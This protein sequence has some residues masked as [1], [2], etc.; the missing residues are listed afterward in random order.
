MIAVAIRLALRMTATAQAE[1]AAMRKA[2]AQGVDDF[3]VADEM[4]RPA[5]DDL[6]FND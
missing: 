1:N 4:K 2:V 5:G 6:T 3:E